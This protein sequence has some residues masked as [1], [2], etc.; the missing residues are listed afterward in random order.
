MLCLS[1]PLNKSKV[2]IYWRKCCDGCR[3]LVGDGWLVYL[4]NA[5]VSGESKY[6]SYK[7]SCVRL[8]VSRRYP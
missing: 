8:L 6:S 5:D 3:V 1:S 7:F 2:L 4:C